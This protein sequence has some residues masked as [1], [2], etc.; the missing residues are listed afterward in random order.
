MLFKKTL[1]KDQHALGTAVAAGL[2]SKVSCKITL[3]FKKQYAGDY[4][5]FSERYKA[6]VNTLLH[7]G[8]INKLTLRFIIDTLKGRSTFKRD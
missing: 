6:K 3:I 1:T 4:V 2:S 5:I 8:E 7:L